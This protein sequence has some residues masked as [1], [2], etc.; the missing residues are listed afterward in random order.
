MV[1]WA[2]KRERSAGN[3]R[4]L[5]QRLFDLANMSK[6]APFRTCFRGAS[7]SLYVT[8]YSSFDQRLETGLRKLIRKP[9]KERSRLPLGDGTW[10]D[11]N[12][13]R[14]WVWQFDIPELVRQ[15]EKR[16]MRLTH[17][18]AGEFSEIQRRLP[19]A[20]RPPLLR[21][22]NLYYRFNLPPAAAIAN[23]LVFTRV[24]KH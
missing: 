13:E 15:M 22:N 9:L 4:Q 2:S 21:L 18:R 3:A 14:L 23:L 24:A 19:S 12:G 10:Y 7:S 1:D 20:A 8:N 6:T 11:M 17:R 16:G 5:V